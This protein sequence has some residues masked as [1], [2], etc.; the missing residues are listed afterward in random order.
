[1]EENENLYNTH[2]CVKYK[3]I[4]Q[5]L[6][7]KFNEEN[8]CEYSKQ[9]IYDVCS[10]LYRDEYASVF[11]SNDILD[12]KIDENLRKLYDLLSLDNDFQDAILKMMNKMHDDYFGDRDGN[13]NDDDFDF[14][15][16]F[17]F[18]SLFSQNLFYLTHTFVC[19]FFKTNSINKEIFEKIFEEWKKEWNE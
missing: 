5:E 10:K 3:S 18:L 16:Y 6:L 2:F 17:C 14:H 11:Y 4:E 7:M 19:D 1:M 8:D 12:D 9:D 13:A 15:K